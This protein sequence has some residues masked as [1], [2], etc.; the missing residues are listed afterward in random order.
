[1]DDTSPSLSK[2][3][4]ER[5]QKLRDLPLLISPGAPRE[6]YSYQVAEYERRGR[7]ELDAC[8]TRHDSFIIEP[9]QLALTAPRCS[10]A[11]ME[12]AKP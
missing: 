12:E 1:M 11:G 4:H 7:E 9:E 2:S 10:Q 3:P 5:V 6:K 8:K